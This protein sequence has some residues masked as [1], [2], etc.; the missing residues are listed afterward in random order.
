ISKCSRKIWI[1]I[2]IALQNTSPTL[3][4]NRLASHVDFVR[5]RVM[6]KKF[7]K[8]SVNNQ[9]T[10]ASDFEAKIDIGERAGEAFVKST[11]LLK[12]LAT[13]KHARAPHR[14]AMP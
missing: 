4:H 12:N 2:R 11:N 8:R 9:V 3:V 10:G 5:M 14:G 7:C 1:L 6:P 13:R